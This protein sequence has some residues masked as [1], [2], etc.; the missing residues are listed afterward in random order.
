M[1]T[2]SRRIDHLYQSPAY[3]ASEKSR[4]GPVFDNLIPLPVS[5]LHGDGCVKLVDKT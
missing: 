5:G 2:R 1:S 3:G 4:R